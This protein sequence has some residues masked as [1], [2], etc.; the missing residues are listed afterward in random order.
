MVR[1]LQDLLAVAFDLCYYA[2][3]SFNEVLDMYVYDIEWMHNRLAEVKK[4]ENEG[5]KE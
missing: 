2:H 1:P 5:M 4:K 3:Q